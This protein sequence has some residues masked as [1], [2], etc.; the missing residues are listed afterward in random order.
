MSQK[1]K[2][3][4]GAL[5][6][7][8][9][10]FLVG[11]CLVLSGCARQL[12]PYG[13]AR[14]ADTIAAYEEFVR[15]NP[16]DP[17]A[18]FARDR[19]EVLRL[20]EAHRSGD[21]TMAAPNRAV[22]QQRVTDRAEPTSVRQGPWN[23][24]SAL[25]RRSAFTLDLYHGDIDPVPHQLRIDQQGEQVTYTLQH[26][27]GPGGYYLTAG[28]PFAAFKRLWAVVAAG[29]VGSF[30]PSY[31]RMGSTADCRG[32]L[33]IEVDT[34]TERLSRM[35]RLEGLNFE[36]GNLRNLLKSMAQMHP[37]DHVVDFFR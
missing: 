30:R 35:I 28:V 1:R 37:E 4:T 34:G 8:G 26:G 9:A 36:D 16:H 20:L 22:A 5:R 12:T 31:G 15:T 29:E 14:K 7:S 17:R 21:M 10:A 13:K 32:S 33:V 6:R 18:R 3:Q 23:L 2:N 19:I 27:S 25:P 24:T 11:M